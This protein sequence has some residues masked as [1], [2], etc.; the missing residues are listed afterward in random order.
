MKA[1]PSLTAEIGSVQKMDFIPVSVHCDYQYSA[2]EDLTVAPSIGVGAAFYQRRLYADETW[3]KTFPAADYSFTYNFRNFAP[4]KKGN[5]LFAVVG[6]SVHYKMF[7]SAG[8]ISSAQYTHY[9]E[10]PNQ[11]GYNE[12]IF[13]NEFSFRIGLEFFY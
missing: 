7:S 6:A 2:A 10:T 3:T 1:D 5:P 8:V 11:F 4:S 12:F 13:L 9:L